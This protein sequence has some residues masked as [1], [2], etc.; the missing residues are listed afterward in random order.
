MCGLMTKWLKLLDACCNIYGDWR[1][2]VQTSLTNIR[3]CACLYYFIS[4]PLIGAILDSIIA[5]SI[6]TILY[7]IIAT[8]ISAAKDK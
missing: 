1:E 2:I 4:T 8:S 3:L 5:T 7:G 6:T